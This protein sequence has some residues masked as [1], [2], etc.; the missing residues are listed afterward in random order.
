MKKLVLGLLVST[1]ISTSVFAN[2]TS[3][4]EAG[5]KAVEAKNYQIAID[6]FNSAIKQ[7][8][9]YADA[10]YE[11]AQ[12]EGTIGK[13]DDSEASI[14]KYIQ[15]KPNETKGYNARAVLYAFTN[16]QE[17]ALK[18][19]DKSISINRNDWTTYN[20]RALVKHNVKDKATKAEAYTDIQRSLE[21]APDKVETYRL[22]ALME[23]SDR[24]WI[25]AWLDSRYADSL[26][27]GT[28]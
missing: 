13:K 12:V 6:Y 11:K 5:K 17:L 26:E 4:F 14:T 28:K 3:D 23:L 10:Y 16:R 20:A 9:N 19:L 15:L 24:K 8:P 7:N 2:A 27:K 21:I 18:D 25:S 1:L 22:K